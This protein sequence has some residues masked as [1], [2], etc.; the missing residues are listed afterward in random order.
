MFNT[1]QFEDI[2]A[3]SWLGRSLFYYPELESTNSH[4]KT[5]G[6]VNAL[7]GSLVLTDYQTKGR[8]QYN[9]QWETNPEENLTF[10]LIFEPKNEQ[11]LT[12]LT[13]SCALAIAEVCGE[14]ID[15][16]LS[17]KWPNDVLFNG[18]KLAGLLTEAI[19]NG[20]ITERVIVG[21][22]ININQ[23][24][25]ESSL[26]D[27][28]ISLSAITEKE[29]SRE[30]LLARILTR[31]EYYYRL[32]VTRDINLIRGINKALS[33]FGTWVSISI[34]GTERKGKYKFLGINEN[35][36]LIV[37]NKELEVDTFSYEQ[38][39]IKHD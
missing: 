35:G 27:S 9:R 33:G 3:T 37:L 26:K 14:Q 32:W 15:S 5:I 11:R 17:I 4:A 23:S 1:Q 21:I 31:I 12:I 28:A 10:S 30:Q 38:V 22:G 34:D 16:K 19:F 39:R 2:L 25:F 36:S 20:N 13:L 8:G 24:I 6:K 29:Y 7:H 18:K